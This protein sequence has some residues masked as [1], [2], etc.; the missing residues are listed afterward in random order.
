[1]VRDDVT[2]TLEL[3][4]FAE[5]I[6]LQLEIGRRLWRVRGNLA[7]AYEAYGDLARAYTIDTQ[8]VATLT[9]AARVVSTATRR[10]L[11]LLNLARRAADHPQFSLLWK[12]VPR[13]IRYATKILLK[14]LDTAVAARK[15]P[16][17]VASQ[18][19]IAGQQRFIIT[20]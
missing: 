20:E 1:L 18:R 12:Q 4:R 19:T 11:P 6:G 5:T 3:L 7:T 2:K 13:G 17:V 16:L 8:L 10:A 15:M 14:S 9:A